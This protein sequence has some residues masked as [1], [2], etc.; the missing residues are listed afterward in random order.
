[1]YNSFS[2]QIAHHHIPVSPSTN[3]QLIEEIKAGNIDVTLPYMLTASCQTQGRGQHNR[4][5]QSP[6]GNVYLSVYHPLESPLSG[7]LS[8]VVGC[9]L[10][11]LPII[12]QINQ[13]RLQNGCETIGVKWAND[14]GFYNLNR[15]LDKPDRNL[16]SQ[17]TLMFNK[18]SGI[19]IEPVL[20]HSRLTGVVVGV[21]LNVDNAPKLNK[22]TQEGMDYQAI[23][24]NQILEEL[25]Q[26]TLRPEDLYLP[27]SATI[28]RAIN[29]YNLFTI[30]PYSIHQFMNDYAAMNVLTGHHLIIQQHDKTIY[31]TASGINPNGSLR[32]TDT[33]DDNKIIDI[34]TGTIS[35]LANTQS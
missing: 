9:H 11:R 10:T 5:W 1:M 25:M 15:H 28:L 16:D 32:L 7:L 3:S 13:W 19:L 34:Y 8:L 24:L 21:G 31:G 6:K 23:S 18:L 22:V 35:V 2:H 33:S 12:Q 14:V 27:I 26:E 29:Q 30:D 20:T 17:C 4:T